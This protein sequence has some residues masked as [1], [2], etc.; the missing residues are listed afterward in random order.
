MKSLTYPHE[1]GGSIPTLPRRFGKDSPLAEPRESFERDIEGRRLGFATMPGA[2]EEAAWL[3]VPGMGRRSRLAGRLRRRGLGYFYGGREEMFVL[4]LS[5]FAGLRVR[6][7]CMCK[8]C[9]SPSWW[10]FDFRRFL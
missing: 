7:K 4:V 3:G 5:F 10:V 6:K 8:V 9:H 1:Q 2:A